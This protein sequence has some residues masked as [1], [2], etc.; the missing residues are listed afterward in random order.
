MRWAGHVAHIDEMKN[1]YQVL[2][3]RSQGEDVGIG[4]GGVKLDNGEVGW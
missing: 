1:T 2:V 4:D 3:G